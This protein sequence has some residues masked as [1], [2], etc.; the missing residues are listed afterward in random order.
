MMQTTF[1][2]G[3]N[4]TIVLMPVSGNSHVV[5][6][7][8]LRS[9]H[10]LTETRAFFD[11]CSEV[12]RYNLAILTNQKHLVKLQHF[13]FEKRGHAFVRPVQQRHLHVDKP[14]FYEFLEEKN[15]VYLTVNH[16][17]R[18]TH[19][20]KLNIYGERLSIVDIDN[21]TEQE[22]MRLPIL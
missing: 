16:I 2:N 14:A 19:V 7:A 10:V 12:D 11:M 5:Q 15:E 22:L 6:I 17:N 13:G 20:A 21:V 3:N 4:C 18:A 1:K 8:H 9:K